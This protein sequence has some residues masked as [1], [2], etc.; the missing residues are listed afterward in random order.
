MGNILVPGQLSSGYGETGSTPEAACLRSL[1]F[2][3]LEGAECRVDHDKLHPYGSGRHKEVVFAFSAAS[4][5]WRARD[6]KGKVKALSNTP[7]RR[8]FC[9]QSG[10]AS[11]ELDEAVN[12]IEGAGTSDKRR[13]LA[14]RIRDLLPL[15]YANYQAAYEQQRG[16]CMAL[17]RSAKTPHHATGFNRNGKPYSINVKR[18]DLARRF[19]A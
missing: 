17:V 3:P 13:E 5:T 6:A 12:E 7:V 14:Q 15:A 18:P 1:G 10:T 16:Q 11:L 19:H 9:D 4:S 8:A 2:Q